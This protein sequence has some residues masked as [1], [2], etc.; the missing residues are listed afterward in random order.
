MVYR[1]S[2]TFGGKGTK[3]GEFDRPIT[4]M[5]VDPRGR[6]LAASGKTVQVF[7]LGGTPLARWPVSAEALCVAA[8]PK[9][10]VMAGHDGALSIHDES[11][12]P[13]TTW[14][15]PDHIGQI[16]AITPA[17]GC[18]YLADARARLI[19]RFSSEGKWL[20]DI[21]GDNPT[22]G[23]HIPNGVLSCAVDAQGVLHAANPG[24]HRVERYS[25]EGKLLS[26]VGRFDQL[27]PAGFPGCC[28]PCTLALDR[29]GNLFVTEKAPPRVKVL[30]PSGRL[31]AVIA[32]TAIDPMARNCPIAVDARGVVFAGDPVRLA[33]HR[34][35]AVS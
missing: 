30:D 22:R 35:E 13:L 34:F 11:G 17:P 9:R 8:G 23:F 1:L 21:G 14:R 12:R 10:T 33:I 24:K 31:L 18:V 19:R 5:A 27:D 26:K 20:N 7:D 25:A 4:G 32:T 6:L 2:K 28:N 15:D 29:T 3:P 16:T